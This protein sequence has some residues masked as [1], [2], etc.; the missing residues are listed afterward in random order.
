MK[1]E[2][3]YDCCNH[4]QHRPRTEGHLNPCWVP[5]CDVEKGDGDD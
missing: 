3:A 4:C 5:G 1:T 2:A